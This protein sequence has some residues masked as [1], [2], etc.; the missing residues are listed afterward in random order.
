MKDDKKEKLDHKKIADKL[1]KYFRKKS[2]IEAAYLFGSQ[3]SGKTT[4][5]SD[6]DV[7]VLIN[8]QII[9][10]KEYPYGYKAHILADLM[11]LLKEN[12]VDLVILND[13]SILLRHRII[14]HGKLVYC[15]D[16]RKRIDFQV[17]T[18][19]KYNTYKNLAKMR[20]KQEV[21]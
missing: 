16:D 10:E 6:I 5:L 8:R 15:A 11:A 3:A 13:A 9:D 4:P 2:E 17:K 20:M 19:D 12:K 1:Q 18:I 21:K 7:A 14:Y